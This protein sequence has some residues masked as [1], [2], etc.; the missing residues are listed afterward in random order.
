MGGTLELSKFQAS[1]SMHEAFKP[2]QKLVGLLG[3]RT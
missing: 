2:G 3:L 1:S